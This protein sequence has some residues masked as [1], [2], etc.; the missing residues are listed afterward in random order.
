M[1]HL[2]RF[3]YYHSHT[4]AHLL[5]N[6]QVHLGLYHLPHLLHDAYDEAVENGITITPNDLTDFG[7]D[8]NLTVIN[9]NKYDSKITPIVNYENI[10]TDQTTKFILSVK[11]SE[12]YKIVITPNRSTYTSGISFD[13][14]DSIAQACSISTTKIDCS[15]NAIVSSNELIVTVTSTSYNMLSF[16]LEASLYPEVRTNEQDTSSNYLLYPEP[17]IDGDGIKNQYDTDDDGDGM[18]DYYEIDNGFSPYVANG[19]DDADN[20]GLTNLE[21][22]IAGTSSSSVDTDEDGVSDF[23]EVKVHSTNP[24]V[25]DTD[26]DGMSDEYEIA[27][28]LNPLLDDSTGDAD[29]DGLTN[30][31]EYTAGSAS[32][33]SD[34][35]GD[36]L[37]DYDEVITH[38]TNPTL[39]DTDNDGMTDAYEIAEGLNPLDG[40]DCPSW[41]CGSSKIWMWK[42]QTQ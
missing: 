18:D 8:P 25:A 24:L 29:E 36:G 41:M 22:Y 17:D 15:F 9:E 21:E 2:H 19:S 37:S 16:S 32:N 7:Y 10:T 40:S 34:T 38:G 26:G 6:H 20:D 14:A 28:G 42:L 39:T 11:N 3:E 5:L 31:Q 30:I 12:T 33:S 27:N 1:P 4:S 13:G 35:D 23:D